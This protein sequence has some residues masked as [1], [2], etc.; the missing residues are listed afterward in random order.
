MDFILSFN[1]NEEVM[2]FPVINNGSVSLNRDQD[3]P[4]FEG[5]YG[6]LQALGNTN[7]ASFTVESIFPNRK[8]PWM[9]PGSYADG[10]YY[11][12]T[13]QNVRERK[14]PFRAIYLD[15]NGRTIFNL[16]VSVEAFEFGLDQAGDIAYRLEFR[17]YRFARTPNVESLPKKSSAEGTPVTVIEPKPIQTEAQAAEEAADAR[18]TMKSGA[19]VTSGRTVTIPSSIKQTGMIASM[20]YWREPKKGKTW[21]AGTTQRA[22]YDIWVANGRPVANSIATLKGYYLIATTLTFGNV[23]DGVIVYLEG[24]KS[25]KCIIGDSKGANVAQSPH[26]GE[27]G[28]KYGHAYGTS[29]VDVIEWEYGL[30]R[31][32][33]NQQAG[34]NLRAG[35]RAMGISGRKVLKM[36]NYGSWIN[37]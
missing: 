5:L 29:G 4:T 23:G 32:G 22:L 20:T 1:N 10:W 18:M 30:A 27:T 15:N 13:I 8:Y 31:T 7:L 37:Q 35:L 12:H 28:N 21:A 36:V 9:R 14:I 33:S 16:P 17:E 6:Q 25:I 24:G 2:T 19:V 3:N 26:A 34:D 11:V